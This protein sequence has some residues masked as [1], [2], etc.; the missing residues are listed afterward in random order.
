MARRLQDANPTFAS[1]SMPS[2]RRQ[3][4]G[5]CCGHTRQRQEQYHRTLVVE[6]SQLM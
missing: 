4:D 2:T 1:T 5:V 3:L 6:H